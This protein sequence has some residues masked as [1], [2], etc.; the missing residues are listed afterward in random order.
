MAWCFDPRWEEVIRWEEMIRWRRGLIRLR[1]GDLDPRRGDMRWWRDERREKEREWIEGEIQNLGGEM[2]W[3]RKKRWECVRMREWV[4]WDRER[5]RWGDVNEER[6][7][8][9]GGGAS[10]PFSP[11]HFAS[12]TIW[13]LEILQIRFFLL[14]S[15]K[16]QF[17]QRKTKSNKF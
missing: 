1:R 6:D 3:R 11:L 7:R 2:K 10:S 9:P 15:S 5:E 12:F 13:P 16:N 4:R 14:L 17:K 8:L